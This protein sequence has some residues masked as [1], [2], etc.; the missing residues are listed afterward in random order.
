MSQAE[1]DKIVRVESQD[2]P[3]MDIVMQNFVDTVSA[4]RRVQKAYFANRLRGDLIEAKRL[5]AA[6]DLV[7]GQFQKEVDRSG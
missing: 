6:V 3:L 2:S 7:V 5:E 1:P 4:M